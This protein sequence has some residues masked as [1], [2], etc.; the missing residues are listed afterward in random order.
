MSTFDGTDLC[1]MAIGMKIL[2]SPPSDDRH[3]VALQTDTSLNLVD[4]FDC[5]NEG[6]AEK[7][8]ATTNRFSFKLNFV[9]TTHTT[10]SHNTSLIIL[11]LLRT[12][13]CCAYLSLYLP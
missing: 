6:R 11:I 3:T 10:T 13:S 2:I 1:G 4:L 5:C 9:P 7:F 12:K 8:L